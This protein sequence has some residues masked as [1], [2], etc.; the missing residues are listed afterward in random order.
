MEAKVVIENYVGLF[1][2]YLVYKKSE[3]VTVTNPPIN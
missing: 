1:Y 2:I 3:D